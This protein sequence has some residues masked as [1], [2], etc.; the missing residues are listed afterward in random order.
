MDGSSNDQIQ[1][2]LE[3]LKFQVQNVEACLQNGK[4]AAKLREA[5]KGVILGAQSWMKV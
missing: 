2:F 3:S 5:S 1:K 4:D